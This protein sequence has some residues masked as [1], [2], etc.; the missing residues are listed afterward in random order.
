MNDDSNSQVQMGTL[1]SN[2]TVIDED[3]LL[4]PAQLDRITQ[5]VMERLEQKML[6]Q[7]RRTQ[8]GRAHV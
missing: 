1:T 4:T 5:A 3:Q 6:N 2:V 7:Q 8:I